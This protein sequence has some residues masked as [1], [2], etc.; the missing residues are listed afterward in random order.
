ML[1]LGSGPDLMA[2]L[3][4]YPAR[5]VPLSPGRRPIPA[6]CSK[7]GPSVPLVIRSDTTSSP[8]QRCGKQLGQRV[9]ADA[10]ESAMT[11]VNRATVGAFSPKFPPA[12]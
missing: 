4:V 7:L 12:P 8:H 3:G 6:S 9:P 11:S 1:E 5:G 2:M 10:R